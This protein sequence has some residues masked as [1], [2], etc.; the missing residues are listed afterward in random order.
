MP[1]WAVLDACVLHPIGLADAL[2]WVAH[3]EIYQPLWSPDILEELRRSV[4]ERLP[5]ANIDRRITA[6]SEAFPEA[7][8][9]GYEATIEGLTNHPGDRHVLAAAIAGNAH[10]IVTTNL[11]HFPTQACAPYDVEAQHPDAFLT[12]ALHIDTDRVINALARQASSKQNPPIT[13]EQL[14]DRLAEMTPAFI[15]EIRDAIQELRARD[16]AQLEHLLGS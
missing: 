11:R 9:S 14:L 4:H 2:L 1:F 13:F 3:V 15:E 6:M 8:V 16:P 5:E 10:V 12:H 7:E